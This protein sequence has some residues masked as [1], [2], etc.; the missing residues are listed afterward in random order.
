MFRPKG[1]TDLRQRVGEG[2]VSESLGK[3][4]LH[5]TDL[6]NIPTPPNPVSLTSLL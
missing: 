3:F 4:T 1:G 2:V 6:L 5:I